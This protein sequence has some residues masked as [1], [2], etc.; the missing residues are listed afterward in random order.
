M[1]ITYVDI[2]VRR[3]ELY[4]SKDMENALLKINKFIIILSIFLCSVYAIIYY[5]YDDYFMTV[6]SFV[7]MALPFLIFVIERRSKELPLSV[8]TP[9]L[10]FVYASAVIGAIGGLYSSVPSYDKIIHFISGLLISW[11]F[12][13]F[14]QPYIKKYNAKLMLFTL[15][16][17][18]GMIALLWEIGEFT[19]D[20]V[21]DKNVQIGLHDTMTDMIAGLVGGLIV[22]LLYSIVNN[23]HE[24]AHKKKSTKN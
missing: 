3:G 1:Y 15:I 17:F 11:A 6:S 14:V 20:F 12:I 22:A 21:F 18:N 16:C 4:M 10:L 5:I 2:I 13:S 8:K 19:F 23:N 7:V 24:I 9:Y